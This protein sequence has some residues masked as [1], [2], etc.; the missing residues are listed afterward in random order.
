MYEFDFNRRMKLKNYKTKNKN[1]LYF[2]IRDLRVKDNWAFIYSQMLSHKYNSKTYMCFSVL[3]NFLNAS[4]RQYSFLKE[5]LEEIDLTSKKF[6]VA[7]HL[8]FGHPSLTLKKFIE[9][10]QIGYLVIEQFPLNIFR[11]MISSFDTLNVN[12]I[13]VDAHNII[14]VWITSNKQEYNAR[15]IRLKINRLKDTYLTDYPKLKINKIKPS[16]RRNDFDKLLS[17]VN[18]NK[19]IP[20]IKN[21]KDF[22]GGYSNGIKILKYFIKEK[23]RFY[24]RD[25]NDA[26][27][28]G[29]SR[30]SAYLH[31]GM[32]SSQ[33]C[34]Y[35]IEKYKSNMLLFKDI[36]SQQ[37]TQ[38]KES[39]DTYIEEIFVRKELSDNF[40]YYNNNY[41][42]ITTCPEWAQRSLI[43]HLT[44]T[45]ENIFSLKDLELFRTTDP[46][47]NACQKYMN[48][49]GYL[50]G[51]L[52]MYWAKKILEWSK[53]PQEAIDKLIY[54]NDT[55]FMDGRDP[56][57]YTNILWSIGALHDRAFGERKIYG[58]IRFMSLNGI[59][60]K[61][62]V[63]LFINYVS[64]LNLN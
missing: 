38:F 20:Q 1:V 42:S 46:L 29:T 57:G 32:I 40:C 60:K 54:L 48:V 30:L 22:I 41:T 4:I 23:V 8:L 5:G 3:D 9:D 15:T 36:T 2:T 53:S 52:R 26:N 16:F 64:T 44:D 58:K 63:E 13:Q 56:I 31:F 18:M 43:S 6:N 55:Y 59:K 12:L 19:D 14:P 50:N 17:Y 47:W 27:I 25:K 61:F 28:Q 34:V 33:R 45:R 21:K 51:Y 49:F 39:C 62:N 10:Y 11:D 35:E 24:S 37:Q 7:F